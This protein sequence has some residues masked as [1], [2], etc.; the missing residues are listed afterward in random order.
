M[1]FSRCIVSK[2]VTQNIVM[3][4]LCRNLHF[5]AATQFILQLDC[6]TYT[7]QNA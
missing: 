1:Q 4:T 3:L 5:P 2:C 7:K 6:E